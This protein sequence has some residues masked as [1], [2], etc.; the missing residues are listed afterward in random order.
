MNKTISII[1]AAIIAI[2]IV[3]F[4]VSVANR[5]TKFEKTAEELSKIKIHIT[6][7]KR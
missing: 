3:V 7:K 2:L 6:D 4:V 5:K 1:I